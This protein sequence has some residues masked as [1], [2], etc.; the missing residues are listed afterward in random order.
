MWP[1]N[2]GAPL[3]IPGYLPSMELH[4]TQPSSVMENGTQLDTREAEW[5]PDQVEWEQEIPLEE[6]RELLK[7]AMYPFKK[8][9]NNAFVFGM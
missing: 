6:A 7:K 4:S 5:N 8:V 2:G 3:I 9:F 1:Y